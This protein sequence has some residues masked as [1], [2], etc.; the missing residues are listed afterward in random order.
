M[1]EF[2]RWST[3]RRIWTAGAPLLCI[4]VA[5]M[6]TAA[7]TVRGRL[8]DITTGEPVAA[9]D[10]SLLYGASGKKVAKRGLTTD[11]GSFSFTNA[12][13]RYRLRA[14][15]IG[16]RTV[17]SPPFDI[18]ASEPLKVE[19]DISIKAVPLA[20]LVVVSP[21]PPL[22]GNLRL[23]KNGFFDR[24]NKWGPI[25][26]GLG[27]FIDNQTIERRQP[28]RISD[29]FMALPRL[30]VVSAGGDK[31]RIRMKTVTDIM[32]G[33]CTPLIYLDGV[34]LRA[35]GDTTNENDI[36]DLV[37]PWS[38]AGIEVY[39]SITKPA[40]FTDL[41]AYPCGAIVIWTR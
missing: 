2:V 18:V 30:L 29:L 31:R 1:S 35:A 22:L 21:R 33:T 38:V 4:F 15:R 25:G 10:M 6:P 36:D 11:S 9:A 28:L 40:R 32:H 3:F 41:S 13:G 12:P 8:V 7:Q 17:V 14:E 26:L 16:Y 23:V 5:T 37:S 19:L 24:E 39:S 27:T 34:P 20:P